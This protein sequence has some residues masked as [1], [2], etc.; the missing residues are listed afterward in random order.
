[1][2]TVNLLGNLGLWRRFWW[3]HSSKDTGSRRAG[4]R[5]G[6]TS[7]SLD[8]TPRAPVSALLLFSDPNQKLLARGL[9]ENVLNTGELSVEPVCVGEGRACVCEQGGR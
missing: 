4:R 2:D 3:S 9:L 7:W 5:V 1:M 8:P 6:I